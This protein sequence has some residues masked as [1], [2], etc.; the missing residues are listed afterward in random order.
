VGIQQRSADGVSSAH[1]FDF[2][3]SG[4]AVLE[5]V[6]ARLGTDSE[7]LFLAGDVMAGRPN[8]VLMAVGTGIDVVEQIFGN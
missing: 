5:R 6:G 3:T 4:L 1:G 2:A 7:G 8:T